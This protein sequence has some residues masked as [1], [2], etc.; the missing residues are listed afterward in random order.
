MKSV[1]FFCLGMAVGGITGYILAK[2][3]Y[4]QIAQEEIDSIKERYTV[5]KGRRNVKSAEDESEDKT[6]DERFGASSIVTPKS[7]DKERR[8]YKAMAKDYGDPNG[9]DIPVLNTNYEMPDVIP[10]AA[11]GEDE[12][13][14]QCYYTYYAGDNTLVDSE[15]ETPVPNDTVAELVGLDT[16]SRFDEYEHG[17]VYSVN[18]SLKMYFRI[19]YVDREFYAE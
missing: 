4:E 17:Y 3:K 7:S 14:E 15:T 6:Y 2:Q 5:P 19:E 13:Y 1:V 16:L 10:P 11:F 9:G 8:D 12:E 18:H